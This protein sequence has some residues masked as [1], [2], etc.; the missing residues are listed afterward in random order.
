MRGAAGD[1]GFI[2]PAH[3]HAQAGKAVAL[4]DVGHKPEMRNR[5]FIDRRDALTLGM[6][7]EMEPDA[8]EVVGNAAGA[9]A[10]L[11]LLREE[12]FTQA[13]EMARA[14]RVLDL[15]AHSDFQNTFISALSF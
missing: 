2:I 14:T 3:A 15:A 13:R 4:G 11:A 6:F 9:G 1:R 5:V 7:P 12:C 10:V 8:I